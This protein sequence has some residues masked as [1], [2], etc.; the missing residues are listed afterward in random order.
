MFSCRERQGLAR[1]QAA[2]RI[3]VPACSPVI[4]AY[5][6][7]RFHA[8]RS[9]EHITAHGMSRHHRVSIRGRKYLKGPLVQKILISIEILKQWGSYAVSFIGCRCRVRYKRGKEP[10]SGQHSA[11][12]RWPAVFS[13]MSMGFDANRRRASDR[14]THRR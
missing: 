10:S 4:F 1:E 7:S 3:S 12:D 14:A 5:T 11:A 13:S 2:Y 6:R 8:H 9:F